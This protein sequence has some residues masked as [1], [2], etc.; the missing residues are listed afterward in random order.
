MVLGHDGCGLF[1]LLIVN[2]SEKGKIWQTSD[3]GIQPCAPSLTFTEWYENW[4]NGNTD[5]WA[6]YES[7]VDIS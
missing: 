2:G 6:G 7:E 1:W 3:M 4:L 5:W